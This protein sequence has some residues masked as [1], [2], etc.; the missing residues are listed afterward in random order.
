MAQNFG[1]LLRSNELS[2]QNFTDISVSQTR[3][4][5]NANERTEE[6]TKSGITRRVAIAVVETHHGA[7]RRFREVRVAAFEYDRSMFL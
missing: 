3:I 6:E 4:N 1:I 7:K 2:L 5:N